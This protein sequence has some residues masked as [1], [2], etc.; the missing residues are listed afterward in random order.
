MFMAFCANCG[1]KMA[2]GA[3]FCPSCG[4]P[5]KAA[6]PAAKP[7]V[8]KVGNIRKCPSCGAEVESFQ[9]RC[10]SCGHEFN[11]VEV[12]AS[13][14]SFTANLLKLDN[15]NPAINRGNIVIMVIRF[16][17][18]FALLLSGAAF[19]SG[20]MDEFDRAAR[21]RNSELFSEYAQINLQVVIP[22]FLLA[23]FFIGAAFLVLILSKPKMTQQEKEKI[24]L[25]EN[26]VVPNTKEE[27]LE[28]FTFAAAQLDE[29]NPL[30][31]LFSSETKYKKIW[32]NI[33]KRKCRQTYAKARVAMGSS[34]PASFAVI[35]DIMRVAKIN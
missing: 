2:G 32:N 22:E 15:K 31:V 17:I 35:Q 13:V 23:L 11:K 9:T 6:A 12:A 25:V 27:L 21:L 5:A 19:I 4:T 7:G 1:A 16:I 20:A 18:S 3:K 34:D 8:E 26:F 30:G 28:F 33:W 10:S 14:K 29:I 24:A